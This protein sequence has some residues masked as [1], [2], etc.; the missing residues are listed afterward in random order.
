MMVQVR[1]LDGRVGPTPAATVNELLID[2]AMIGCVPKTLL[3]A[4]R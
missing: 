3:L 2:L 4:E 1:E